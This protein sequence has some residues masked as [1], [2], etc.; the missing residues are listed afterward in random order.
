MR[1]FNLK[2]FTG[3]LISSLMAVGLTPPVAVSGQAI[4]LKGAEVPWAFHTPWKRVER[5]GVGGCPRQLYRPMREPEQA[6]PPESAG[7]EAEV[8]KARLGRFAALAFFGDAGAGYGLKSGAWEESLDLL[9]ALH[10][11]GTTDLKKNDT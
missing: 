7:E 6:G 3:L 8:R 1:V 10:T 2:E 11:P 5:K 9:F 4:D